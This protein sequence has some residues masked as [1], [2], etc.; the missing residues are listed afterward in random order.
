MRIGILGS[1]RMGGA[2]GTLWARAGHLVTFS[3]A[4]DAQALVRLAAAAGHG[5]RAGTPREAAEG[6]DV[7]LLAVPWEQV[8]D[9]LARAG[10]LDGRVL[11][12]CVSALRP[13]F[14]GQA[15]GI[16]GSGDRSA[17]EA[18]AMRAPGARV[19]EAFNTTFAEILAAPSRDFAGERPSL[20][21]CGD[22]ADARA[23][24]RALI[25]D[26]GYD[27]VDVGPLAHARSLEALA[28][29]WVQLAVVAGRH[30]DVALRILGR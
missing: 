12:T 18:I 4:R 21:Y 7:V 11:V 30:P 26:C 15:T 23:T 20:L 14:S 6:A 9:V 13:D 25:E 2:I 5:A 8:D 10:P 3:Y 16:A 28:S 1:G 24:V 29:V 17:A 27:P 22:D 19:V